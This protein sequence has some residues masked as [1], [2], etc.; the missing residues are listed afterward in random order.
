MLLILSMHCV[1]LARHFTISCDV[2]CALYN[3]RGYVPIAST[4]IPFLVERIIFA[5]PFLELLRC[6]EA[7]VKS[8]EASG[9]AEIVLVGRSSI[10]EKK[11][12]S[13]PFADCSGATR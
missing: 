6:L 1:V 7:S 4:S 13:I 11:L 9:L 3:S 2:S 5:K 8:S 10:V 12:T